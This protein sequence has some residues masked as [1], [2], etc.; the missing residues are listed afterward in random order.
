VKK[1]LFVLASVFLVTSLLSAQAKVAI[2]DY[3]DRLELPDTLAKQIAGLIKDQIP[4]T[5][6]DQYSG[7]ANDK[8]S[9]EA[10]TKIDGAGYALAILITSDAVIVGK[11]YLLKT[12]SLFAN[13]NNPLGLGFSSTKA[14]GGLM[15]GSSYYV[16]VDKK[17]AFFQKI[18][19]SLKRPGFVF[20]GTDKSRDIELAES[21]TV[22][23]TLG[24]SFESA[25][26][27]DKTELKGAVNGL[28][29]KGVD[30]VILTTSGMMYDNVA[31]I[32]GATVDKKVPVFS[33]HT[34]GVTNGAVAALGVDYY[35]LAQ[36]KLMSMVK[37]VLGGK[38]PGALDI[39]FTDTADVYL[40]LKAAKDFGVA[41]PADL[42]AGAKKVI[43]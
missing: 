11:H 14:P 6:V 39:Q 26:I 9:A 25:V 16:S 28:L 8:T 33:F 38:S 27:R 22:A 20:D 40:N 18:L 3:D 29:A 42:V 32:Y 1:L 13:A 19:P 24:L 23:K 37:A 2:F 17:M 4:G 34:K 36:K 35:V 7:K 15:S 21:R 5:V 43:Q 10:L 41:V 31:D 30:A 12:P